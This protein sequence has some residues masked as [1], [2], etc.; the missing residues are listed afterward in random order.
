M[1]INFSIKIFLL[2]FLFSYF[3][4]SYSQSYPQEG[5][6]VKN[7]KSGMMWIY[8]MGATVIYINFYE[9][10]YKTGQLNA[11]LDSMVVIGK[12]TVR[13][14]QIAGVRK[15]SP[16]HN[17][18]RI[19]GLPL[20]LIGSVGMGDGIFAMTRNENEFAGPKLF[21]ISAGIFTLGYLPYLL[22]RKDLE[23]GIGGEWTLE[24][25]WKEFPSK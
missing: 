2:F 13:L 4:K 9:N 25:L 18:A 14:K 23:V 6:L 5:L 21:L 15:K 22:E 11:L 19:I 20:M 1:R 24:I 7:N 16:L 17:T 3:S 10:E 8:E 12:D